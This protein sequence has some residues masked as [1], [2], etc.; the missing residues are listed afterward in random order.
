MTKCAFGQDEIHLLGK[1]ISIQGIAPL[2][3]KIDH[4][5]TNPKLPTS[6]KS[7]QPFAGFVNIYRLLQSP[8]PEI[9]QKTTPV[10]PIVAERDEI[11]TGE[12]KPDF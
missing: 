1:A 2:P 10:S 5:L 12:Q 3:A 9:S 4:L 8:N 6:L 7:L 11:S